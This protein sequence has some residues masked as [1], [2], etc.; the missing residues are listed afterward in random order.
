[1]FEG[2]MGSLLS[3]VIIGAVLFG[4]STFLAALLIWIFGTEGRRVEAREP[5]EI[6]L[7]RAA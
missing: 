4:L 1:M 6:R 3:L 2:L 7:R 5:S